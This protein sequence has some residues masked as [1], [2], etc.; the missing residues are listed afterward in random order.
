MNSMAP[1]PPSS[2]PGPAPKKA[3]ARAATSEPDLRIAG[4]IGAELS[5]SIHTMRRIVQ[6]FHETHRV[7]RV[8]MAELVLALEDA[9]AIAHQSQQLARLAEGRLRQSHERVSLDLL[10]DAALDDRLKR[11]QQRG[12]EVRRAIKPVEIVVDP[13]LLSDLVET[14]MDWALQRHQRMDVSLGINHWPEHGL[15]TIRTSQAVSTHEPDYPTPDGDSLKWALLSQ[16]AKAMGVT[17]SKVAEGRGM[18]LTMEFA[19]T[20]R[21]LEGLTSMEIEAS[22]GDSAFHTGTKA[23]AGLRI[24]LISKDAAIRGEVEKACRSLGLRPDTVA[25]TEK[26]VRYTEREQPHM[27]IV[28]ERLRDKVFND[29]MQDIRRLEPNFGFLEV[30]D[31]ADTFEVSGW[32]GDSMTRVSRNVLRQHL[33]SVLMLELAKAF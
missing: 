5:E 4:I 13:G 23:L 33:P 30:T 7:S 22:A 10:V 20:V 19:R 9:S 3:A 16:I 2:P 1:E 28:D 25:D 29:L 31:D 24:L 26:A 21:H 14:A 15:L 27:I 8:Q 6:V 32:M 17:L 11:C 12:I 18:I